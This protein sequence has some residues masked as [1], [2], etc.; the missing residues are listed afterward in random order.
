MKKRKLINGVLQRDS[1]SEVGN[2]LHKKINKM[3]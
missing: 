2:E 3:G 1:I